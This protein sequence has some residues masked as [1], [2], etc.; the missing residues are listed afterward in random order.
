MIVA[1]SFASGV[2]ILNRGTGVARFRSMTGT[3]VELA[4]P[5]IDIRNE[6]LVASIP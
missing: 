6:Q 3:V 5:A 1:I 4:Y 2:R